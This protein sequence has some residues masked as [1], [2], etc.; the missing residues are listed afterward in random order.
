M[1]VISICNNKGGVGKTTTATVMSSILFNQGSKVLLI[2]ADAQCNS[3]DTCGID[4]SDYD[5]YTLYDVLSNKKLKLTDSIVESPTC[6]FDVVPASLKLC[7]ISPIL[8]EN[9]I[10]SS[11]IEELGSK[12]KY[13]YIIIDCPPAINE[14]LYNILAASNRVVVPV[15]PDKYS[16]KGLLTLNDFISYVI[17][18]LNSDLSI[19]GLLLTNYSGQNNLSISAKRSLEAACKDLGMPMFKSYIRKCIKVSEAQLFQ[20]TV[21]V[22]SPKCNASL[23]Y[24]NFIKEFKKV[25]KNK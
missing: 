15:N 18:E 4:A 19:S 16:M 23:D 25:I 2:D 21:D 20:T 12:K 14:L 24:F 6:H 7:N 17:S 8:K 10:F 22:Y 1:E 13:D 9:H 11:Y 5:G 3:T